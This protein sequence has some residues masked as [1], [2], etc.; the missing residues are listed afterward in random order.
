MH[1]HMNRLTDGYF[2]ADWKKENRV[3]I[4]KPGKD[5]YNECNAYRTVSVTD[6]IGKR[7]EYV[8]AQS[9]ALVLDSVSLIMHSLHTLEIAVL[10]RH[11]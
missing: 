9:L 5:D 8:T 2:V 3:I 6:C 4:P 1:T 11:Q 7:F 10:L